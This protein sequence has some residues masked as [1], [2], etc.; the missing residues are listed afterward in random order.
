[1]NR[2]QDFK[3][4]RDKNYSL[5]WSGSGGHLNPLKCWS[6]L[7]GQVMIFIMKIKSTYSMQ[8]SGVLASPLQLKAPSFFST[9]KNQLIRQRP[10]TVRN[11]VF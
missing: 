1:M 9:F 11:E 7:S 10:V 5:T 4:L 8:S 2:I 3:P 6:A